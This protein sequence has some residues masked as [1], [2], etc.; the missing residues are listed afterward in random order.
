MTDPDIDELREQTE[1]TDRASME[2][3]P[4]DFE[5]DLLEKIS[6][7]N[8]SGSQRS[9]SIWNANIA[10][11]LDALE[12]NPER[13]EEIVNQAAEKF[14]ISVD[15]DVDRSEI[16][17]VLFMSGLAATDPDLMESWRGAIG[18]YASQI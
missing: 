7:R 14:D 18:E 10:A 2:S 12:Q 6:E 13:G 4:D 8:E 11:L 3:V 16:V 1:M 17:R 5:D 15:D 9:V